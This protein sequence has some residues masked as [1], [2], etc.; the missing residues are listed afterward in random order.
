MKETEGI[1]E[2]REIREKRRRK[3]SERKF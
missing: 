3:L 1:K 2:G